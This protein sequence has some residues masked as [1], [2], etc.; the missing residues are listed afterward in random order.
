MLFT[1]FSL[2]M[3][4]FAQYKAEIE[5]DI[6]MEIVDEEKE[7]HI[8]SEVIDKRT[9]NTKQFLMSDG[10]YVLAQYNSSVHYLTNENEWVD[11]DNTL[12][13]NAATTVQ[14][15]VFGQ[16]NIIRTKSEETNIVF[17]EK[18]NSNT[19]VFFDDEK[20]PISLNY[21]SMKN[22]RAEITE[23][24]T[25]FQGDEEFLNLS[26]LTDEIIYE[27]A[28]KN[29]DLQYIVSSNGIKENIILK[30]ASAQNSFVVNYNIG[31]LSAKAISKNEIHLLDGKD[32]IYVLSAPVMYDANGNSS[33]EIELNI[34]KNKNGK[35]RFEIL[36]DENW[37]STAVYPVTID[38]SIIED[39]NYSISGICVNG[40]S[41]STEN[42]TLS[43]QGSY[44]LLDIQKID[45]NDFV[46]HV[47]SAKL[48]LPVVSGSATS[49]GRVYVREITGNWKSDDG[50]T[51]T[52]PSVATTVED[53]VNITSTTKTLSFDLT[54]LYSKWENGGSNKGIKLEM[55]ASGSVR[56]ETTSS[57]PILTV[58]YM[59]T[60]GLD[61]SM[62]YTEFDMGSAGYVY[63]NNYSGNLVLT[64]DDEISTTGEEYPYDFSMT[65]NSL[66]TIDESNSRWLPSYLSGF[67]TSFIYTAP[68]GT[69]QLFV[70]G[71]DTAKEDFYILKENDYGWECLEATEKRSFTFPIVGATIKIPVG[72]DACKSNCTEKYSFN[73]SGLQKI[74]IGEDLC[75]EPKNE[76]VILSREKIEGSSDFF[77]VDGSGH[78]LL[79]SETDST[80]TLTQ[81]IKNTDGTYAEG[82]SVTYTFDDDGNVVQIKRGDAVE[83]TF[84]YVED[85]IASIT[86]NENHTVAFEYNGKRIT[87]ITE[88]RGTETGTTVSFERGLNYV[89]T[90]TVGAD[91]VFDDEDDLLTTYVFNNELQV[92]STQC[93]TVEGEKLGAVGLEHSSQE[94]ILDSISKLHA[95][96]K[97]SDNLVKNHNVESVQ[98]W[99]P[100]LL[101]DLNCVSTANYTTEDSYVGEGSLKIKVTDLTTVGA[102]TFY[103]RFNLDEGTI[104]KGKT[105][106]FSA[107]VKTSGITHDADTGTIENY[108]A[109]LM[110]RIFKADGTSTRVYSQNI[111]KTNYDINN[112]WE[113][114]SVTFTLPE[115]TTRASAGLLIRNGTGTAYFDGVQLEEGDVAS[116]YNMLENNGF[117]FVESTGYASSWNRWNMTS[118]DVVENGRMK[119]VGD[120]TRQKAVLQEVKVT[121]KDFDDKFIFSGWAEAM[122]VPKNGT[123]NYRLHVIVYYKETNSN[124]TQKSYVPATAEYNYY[125]DETQFTSG[126]FG[127]RH[128][129]HPEYTPNKI[130]VV[131]CYYNQANTA[132]YDSIRLSKSSDVYDLNE[133]YEDATDTETELDPYTYDENGRVLTYTD[134]EGVVYT[135]SYNAYGDVTS[136]LNADGEGDRFEYNTY[137]TDG[138]G[139]YDTTRI[140]KETYQDGTVYEYTYNSDLEIIKETVIVPNSEGEPT[141]EEYNY[142]EN[143]NL[144]TYVVDNEVKSSYTYIKPNNNWLIATETSNGYK[145]TYTYNPETDEL[146][147]K[148]KSPSDNVDVVIESD[149]YE[150]SDGN[151]T[152]HTHMENG[153]SL[154][155]HYGTKGEITKVEHN[156]FAYNY[157][158]DNFGNTVSVMVGDQPLV[159]YGYQPDNSKLETKA[160]GNNSGTETY[161]YN[162]Y[163]EIVNKN[164]SGVGDYAYKY[165]TLSRLVYEN[166]G[167][168]QLE[169]Y[170]LYDD[171]GTLYGERVN[172]TTKTNTDRNQLY[173]V[174]NTFDDD[175]N[176]TKN[177][178]KT[179]VGTLTTTYTYGAETGL[180]STVTMYGGNQIS[181]SYDDEGT[182]TGRSLSTSTPVAEN[183]NY[184]DEGLISTH[185]IARGTSSDAYSYTYDDN[186]NITEIKKG[187]TVQQ[188]YEYD[189]LN[190]LVR[191]NDR[192]TGKTV[193]Y[194]YDGYG[195]ITSKTEYAFTLGELGTVVDTISYA[196]NDTVWKDKL[197]SY[198]G[199]SISYDQI[200]NPTNYMGADMTWF[201]RQMMSYSK[202]GTSISY[203]YDA[204]GLR[205]SKTVNGVKHNYYYVDGQLRYER[206]G[207][208]YEIYYTYDADGRPVL[209]TKRDLVAQK[210][211]QYY[212]ITNTRGDVIETRNGDGNVNA[213]FVYDAW[214]KLISVTNASGTP[215]AN[216]SFAYQIS[217]K[218]RGYVY[219]NE[220][221]LY[222]LQ[223]R[224][225]DPETGRF[226][227]ADD[228]E[229]IGASGTMLG[230]NAFAYCGNEPVGNSDH[231]GRS[232]IDI[233]MLSIKN[234]FLNLYNKF[235]KNTLSRYLKNTHQKNQFGKYPLE[236]NVSNN[237]IK[238]SVTFR[239]IGTLQDKRY[240]DRRFYKTYKKLFLEGIEDYWEEEFTVFGYDVKIKVDA[241]ESKNSGIPVTM[242]DS[243]GTSVASLSFN[244][245]SG[246]YGKI[247]I[248]TGDN[249]TNHFY[250]VNDYKFVAAHEFGH[251][252]GVN[253]IWGTQYESS[254]VSVFNKINT[255]V[256]NVDVEMVLLAFIYNKVIT[257]E[258]WLRLVK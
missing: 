231:N 167:P 119:I 144:D 88:T 206:N 244:P 201:G 241:K 135:Y 254:V 61:S 147:S 70:E 216:D 132:E 168:S 78:K 207:D 7:A 137:D 110:M 158:Y 176:I 53:Y 21:Q 224:Y 26:H 133:M 234:I 15:E 33:S 177:A 157:L 98:H 74:T 148:V 180:P 22:S 240:N 121:E 197:T 123:R 4:V 39:K 67:S 38:P 200:G 237:T 253:D 142:D 37:L 154:T 13:E 17:A 65:Y 59:N 36:P 156:G 246:M 236:V 130:R 215:L 114:I 140:R 1:T 20:Y 103:Q 49:S 149:S 249:R 25:E 212:L 66:A 56:F 34:T 250:S 113:R 257:Y 226:I 209:A 139:S 178:L 214:G 242:H 116:Q 96:G 46:D 6:E 2:V 160:Y 51:N 101:D 100:F 232:S 199:Q 159:T 251:I 188:S 125:N 109:A 127:L 69:Q 164:I 185:T 48:K 63:V 233:L 30:N 219:D 187:N 248:Y 118:S 213:K 111:Q 50:I 94:T 172:T 211:Y 204:D 40:T 228:V 47:V 80:Y 239:F 85:K 181:Y 108:G 225:Y 208:N 75:S 44:A 11:I 58:Q 90:R 115:D 18:A 89:T 190:Q 81:Y 104:E 120:A 64:R 72:F 41:T 138:D 223:S 79:V 171:E 146:V 106:T 107:F 54:G 202:N 227:N 258:D 220:T 87:K 166:D 31:E 32:V 10:S 218:Y 52:N 217:L 84:A 203:T 247:D 152:K 93:E 193:T 43:S 55:G 27:D 124:G 153:T 73:T 186:A 143:G 136:I 112:G 252:L 19:L 86:D 126:S 210:N 9:E 196:Y 222:Y 235:F 243:Y 28:Y 245:Q 16:S 35:I 163:G 256:Q 174:I 155:Y 175:G 194:S 3:P 255:P 183:F 117:N 182:L 62:P 102:S 91:G 12:Y 83:A 45:A 122:P 134:E 205:T 145:T 165:D 170:Y 57:E 189:A 229:Y 191:E 14:A 150:Y 162:A 238:I 161:T 92:I 82:E 128:P 198:D 129:D 95:E 29:V 131:C 173:Q 97:I 5:A 192:D 221:G 151:V 105:Y 42:F 179:H 99:T 195:N 76:R 24:S 141:I 184:N 68:D 169:T 230:Y 71:E 60:C 23:K 8:I 77:I